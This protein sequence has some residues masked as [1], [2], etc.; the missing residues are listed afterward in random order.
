MLHSSALISAR[1]VGASTVNYSGDK[2]I[3]VIG[4]LGPA[5]TMDFCHRIIQLTPIT[6]EQDH[7]QIL[8]D[9]NPKAPNRN[10]AIAGTGESPA[11]CFLRSARWLESA[12]ADFL[13]MP[14][15][16]AHAFVDGVVAEVSIPF[17]SVIDETVAV[18][19]R[20][21]ESVE[22]SDL[23]PAKPPQVGLLAVDGAIATALYQNRLGA[24]GIET[25]CLEPAAQKQFMQVI[26]TIKQSGVTDKIKKQMR[27]MAEM[28]VA[29]GAGSVIAGCTEVPLALG[30][31]D[32]CVP[33]FDSSEI[34]AGS[35]VAFAKN[36][37]PLPE[38]SAAKSSGQ[39]RVVQFN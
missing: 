31:T 3:G 19:V 1:P 12:G 14:C 5:A 18:V 9:N 2:I 17:V 38:F 39:G 30:P 29:Q 27:T 15:N 26:Y 4:G 34:L 13:A 8:I 10:H 37:R 23:E 22:N 6:C 36:L 35:C 16:T 24:M 7:L 20:Q 33:L 32:L 25:I 11:G 28:L 21:V